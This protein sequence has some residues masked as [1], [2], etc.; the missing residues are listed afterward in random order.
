VAAGPPE[1]QCSAYPDCS[2]APYDP[3][4]R[5]ISCVTGYCYPITSDVMHPSPNGCYCSLGWSGPSCRTDNRTAVRGA[6]HARRKRSSV[7]H[8]R[9]VYRLVRSRRRSRVPMLLAWWR[10]A[11]TFLPI[12][13]ALLVH[14]L[15]YGRHKHDFVLYFHGGCRDPRCGRTCTHAG[16]ELATNFFWISS[17]VLAAALGALTLLVK[18]PITP[19]RARAALMRCITRLDYK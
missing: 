10:C 14:G 12:A 1:P 9:A 5:K 3:D 18:C 6:S 16:L 11:H 17:S 19:G 13:L 4:S 8:T 15:I 2:L 7:G